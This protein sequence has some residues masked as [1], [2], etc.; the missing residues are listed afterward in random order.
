[1][2][3]TTPSGSNTEVAVTGP[4]LT[5]V[6]RAMLS[7]R[8]DASVAQLAHVF[9][10]RW[11]VAPHAARLAFLT[12]A[13]TALGPSPARLAAAATAYLHDA[14]PQHEIQL[15]R[16]SLSE[17]QHAFRQLNS[18]RGGL[19]ALIE[20]REEIQA[21]RKSGA[22]E[23]LEVVND[24]LAYLLSSW[25]SA[26]SL[27]FREINWESPAVLIEQIIKYESVHEVRDWNDLRRRL[28]PDRRCY[29]FF[30]PLLGDEPIIFVEIALAHGLS[31]SIDAILGAPVEPNTVDQMDT[32][33]FYSISNCHAGLR[34]ILF[35]SLLLKRAIEVLSHEFPRISRF[36]TLSPIPG[37]RQWLRH[38]MPTEADRLTNVD[39]ADIE[40]H[41]D[42]LM[43]HCAR[44]L[45]SIGPDGR[46]LDAVGRFHLGNGAQ[47][48]RLNWRAD[49]STKAWTQSFGMM[50]NY[51]YDLDQLEFNVE[52]LVNAH[53]VAVDDRI[54]ELFS[55]HSRRSTSLDGGRDEGLRGPGSDQS[56]E[57][58]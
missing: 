41:H 5:N 48:T 51:G 55:S 36:G 18:A 15:F 34:G 20:M 58:R 37:F 22:T 54:H 35:G 30:H 11:D 26:G 50:V 10:K 21:A 39:P 6:V 42:W 2:T 47:V 45:I 40:H 32:A 27:T 24:E 7:M 29:G 46:P 31:D 57:N 25:L 8:D 3:S 56:S 9:L 13:A 4:M 38:E 43:Q 14:S 19:A 12:D 23:L 16:A 28:Q 17:R 49:S 1:M 53:E 33:V 52:A 44:Y